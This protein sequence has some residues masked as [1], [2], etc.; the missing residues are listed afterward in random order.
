M[1][2]T[3]VGQGLLPPRPPSL[4]SNNDE[5]K[6]RRKRIKREKQPDSIINPETWHFN[7][8]FYSLLVFL[9]M[10]SEIFTLLIFNLVE[11]LYCKMMF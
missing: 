3:G 7:Y 1:A 4:E 11:N 6:H 9:P 8:L 10:I 2:K 5:Q